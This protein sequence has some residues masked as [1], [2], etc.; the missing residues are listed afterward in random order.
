MVTYFSFKF[1]IVVTVF[2]DRDWIDA[3]IIAHQSF[4]SP[5]RQVSSANM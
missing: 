2:P 1:L 3:A 5:T 4:F